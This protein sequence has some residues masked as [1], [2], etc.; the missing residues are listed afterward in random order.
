MIEPNSKTSVADV[1]GHYDDLDHIYRD[2][3]G[4]HVHH[5]LWT[6]G[7]E[8]PAQA[9]AELSRLIA[10]EAGIA[11]GDRVCDVG[12]GYGGTSRLLVA[13]FGAD[14]TGLTVSRVQYDYAVA[15]TLGQDNPRFLVR[16]WEE[17]QF[18]PSSFDAVIS[19][20]CLAHVPDKRKYFEEIH[21]VLR[22]GRMA[23]ITAWLSAER[24][25]AWRVRHLLE[26]ICREGRLPSMGSASEYRQLIEAAGLRLAKQVSLSKQVRKTWSV[27]GRRALAGLVRRREYRRFLLERP[28]AN[29]VFFV[30][31]WRI[32]LAYRIGA[33]DYGLFV[34]EKPK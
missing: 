24:P 27:C 17:N 9:T 19:I 4:E 29:W 15:Q 21:R 2:V 6:T 20:E 16:N 30:T 32:L 18:E 25:G 8:S 22:P 1:A 5:G 28:T 26:P 7:K 14:V 23:A 13:E 3:W 11:P 31:L 10:R 34:L 33:M 12:C